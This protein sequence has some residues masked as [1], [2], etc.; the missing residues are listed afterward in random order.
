MRYPRCVAGVPGI[1]DIE[2]RDLGETDD[3]IIGL[4]PCML[5]QLCR[6]AIIAAH[7]SEG[8]GI[9][10]MH[11]DGGITLPDPTTCQHLD[12]MTTAHTFLG[13]AQ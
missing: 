1:I 7:V 9:D 3:A 5:C 4:T 13:N 12:T 10:L 2:T 6:Q 11:G 8:A